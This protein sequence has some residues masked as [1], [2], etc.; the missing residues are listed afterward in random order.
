MKTPKKILI[1]APHPDDEI[2]GCGGIILNNIDKGNKVFVAVAT[3]RGTEERR[4]E[5]ENVRRAAG[6]EET[7]FLDMNEPLEYTDS[8]LERC[9]AVLRKVKPEFVF[10]PHENEADRDHRKANELLRDAVWMAKTPIFKKNEKILRDTPSVLAYEV[11]T[12]LTQVNHYEDISSVM[13]R[14]IKLL[15]LYASQ[16]KAVDYCAAVEGLNKYRGIMGIGAGYAEAFSILRW[17]KCL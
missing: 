9:I 7:I 3:Y 14:K 2:I 10:I 17:Q 5:A 6:I 8:N 1:F 4:T 16:I 11:H 15:K 12:P 13:R